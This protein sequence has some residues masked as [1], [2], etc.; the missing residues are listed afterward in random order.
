MGRLSQLNPN[1]YTSSGRISS[2]FENVIRYLLA[3][4]RGN[5][6]LGE[7]LSTIF[8]DDGNVDGLVELRLNSSEGL[9][10]RSGQYDNPEEGWSVLFSLDD[11]RGASGSD[12][13]TVV[14]PIMTSRTDYDGDGTEDTFA[15]VYDTDADQVLVFVDGLLQREGALYDYELGT[16]EV[17]FTSAPAND[18][19]ITFFKIRG[20]ASIASTRTDTTPP[21]TQTVF[22]YVFPDEAYELYIYKNGLLQREGGSHDYILSPGTNTITFLSSVLNTDTLS[23]ITVVATGLTTVTGIMTEEDFV[24]SGSG[25]IPFAKL[26]IDNGEI[27][28]GKVANLTTD[29]AARAKLTV[30]STQPVSP[31]TGQLWLD[32]SQSPNVLYFYDG[33]SFIATTPSSAIPDFTSANAGQYLRVNSS[34]TGLVIQ[35]ID[36]SGLIPTTQ[37]GASNGVASLDTNGKIPESQMPEVRATGNLYLSAAG[38]ITNGSLVIT[39]TYKQ[40]IRITG[41]SVAL[42][43]GT[44]QVQLEVSGT[45]VGS[46]YAASS[47]PLD[48]TLGTLIEVD[49][50]TVS[51]S[52]GVDVTSASSSQDL[53]VTLAV[54]Y[55]E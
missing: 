47:T 5:K 39:R 28:Q 23:F 2:E 4:E 3:A 27:P 6:T 26:T 33:I 22:A 12:V 35:P 50:R 7:L 8:D 53:L 54:E 37:K 1:N 48:Q 36:L 20:D 46:L 9:E 55:L 34:G 40:L 52:I 24:D 13:G 15:Y 10:Y 31:S 51:K 14:L 41:I 38:A 11:I 44:C 42:T 30:S 19:S 21:S 18:A 43:S 16:D 32:T 17:I 25:K 29:L 45:P 49:S